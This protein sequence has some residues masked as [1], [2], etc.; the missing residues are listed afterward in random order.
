MTKRTTHPEHLLALVP[1]PVDCH[2]NVLAASDG[3]ER[4]RR[5]FRFRSRSRFRS[6]VC[7]GRRRRRFPLAGASRRRRTFFF[8][9]SSPVASPF[10]DRPRDPPLGHVLHVQRPRAREHQQ[11]RDLLLRGLLHRLGQARRNAP[12]LAAKPPAPQD[13][14]ALERRRQQGD[15][16]EPP[17]DL[18]GVLED[19]EPGPGAKALL[20]EGV[21]DADGAGAAGF[22]FSVSGEEGRWAGG[23]VEV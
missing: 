8:S 21:A 14:D 23:E 5:R 17:A 18:V 19:D 13:V 12:P 4:Q 9:S 10:D 16:R 20:R 6:R 3:A 22:F 15:R 1:G 11:H 7:R 2:E